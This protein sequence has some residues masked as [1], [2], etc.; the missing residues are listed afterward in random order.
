MIGMDATQINLD[1]IKQKAIYGVAAQPLYDE[2]AA[3]IVIADK[4]LR[5]EE[6]PYQTIIVTPIITQDTPDLVATAYDIASKAT[7]EVKKLNIFQGIK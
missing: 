6:V 5:G 2:C 7:E 4:I 3:A 1:L